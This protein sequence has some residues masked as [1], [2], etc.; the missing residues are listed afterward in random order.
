M[1]SLPKLLLE[2][3]GRKAS[4]V[5][6]E[7]GQS[8]SVTTPSGPESFGDPLTESDLFEALTGVLGPDQ[9]AELA[10]G[11]M[12]EFRVGSPTGEWRMVIEPSL[13]GMII[14]GRRSSD[15]T[16]KAKDPEVS[17]PMDLPPLAPFEPETH[18]EAPPPRPVLK[19]RTQ[20]DIGLS[21]Y[22]EDDQAAP[23]E[24]EGQVD[25]APP[26]PTVAASVVAARDTAE[27]A[28]A[29]DG[30][31]P[32]PPPPPVGDL[33]PSRESGV[34]FAIVPDGEDAAVSGR[35]GFVPEDGLRDG[36]VSDGL[37]PSSRDSEPS[38]GPTVP[39]VPLTPAEGVPVRRRAA[40]ADV[41]NE[42]AHDLRRLAERWL[43]GTLC[44][45]AIDEP[46]EAVARVGDEPV[47][48]L[49]EPAA[50][51]LVG[52]ML[53]ELTARATY[54]V[55]LEDPSRITAW[56]LRRL[57][58]GSRVM[59]QTRAVDLA[60]AKRIFLGLH[61][62]PAERWLAQHAVIWLRDTDAVES[63]SEATRRPITRGNGEPTERGAARPSP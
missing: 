11:N 36:G 44:F 41:A 22:A 34:D 27:P 63:T 50:S 24:A 8:P 14:R 46:G 55:Q 16:A 33:G 26:A 25:E 28:P 7:V 18:G 58:E 51:D 9:Q 15:P 17:T 43:P 53:S 20:F 10:V 4:E 62:E 49:D 37:A 57:E 5:V 38:A 32:L 13:V 31:S 1:I 61:G 6:L 29:G 48:V 56:V 42:V 12:V 52:L 23:T 60:G 3:A 30:R 21:T 39:P 40:D 54:V 47:A 2:A 59:V 19:R 35:D 45:A